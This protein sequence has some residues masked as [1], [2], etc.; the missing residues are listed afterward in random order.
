M[1][2][3]PHRRLTLNLNELA[4]PL[5]ALTLVRENDIRFIM[6]SSHPFVLG[7]FKRLASIAVIILGATFGALSLNATDD[8]YPTDDTGPHDP[9][10]KVP[11]SG[12]T[13]V[14]ALIGAAALLGAKR[15]L[16]ESRK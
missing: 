9:L 11:D 4:R 8:Y 3:P 1:R 6:K 7:S 12:A 10:E 13:M 5:K 14:L 16:G 2:Q 15:A